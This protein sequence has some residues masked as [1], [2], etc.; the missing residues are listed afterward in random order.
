MSHLQIIS[1]YLVDITAEQKTLNQKVFDEVM[2][3][4]EPYVAHLLTGNMNDVFSLLYRLDVSEEKV[5]FIL[6]GDHEEQTSK[7][8]AEAILQREIIRRYY[9]L[10]YSAK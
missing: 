8:L 2:A 6:F 4:L 7:L 1:P 9:R 10:K 5:K 3:K